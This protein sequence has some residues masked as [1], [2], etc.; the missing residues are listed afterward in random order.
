[1]IVDGYFLLLLAN[2]I[3]ITSF[4]VIGAFYLSLV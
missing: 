3:L 2:K 1:M 4:S